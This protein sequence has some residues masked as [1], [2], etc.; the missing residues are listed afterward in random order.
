MAEE[1]M[2]SWNIGNVT[3]T[4]IVEVNNHTDPLAVLLSEGSPEL[5]KKYDW[6][7][8]DYATPEGDMKISFQCFVIKA[9]N[10]RIMID[11]CIGNDRRRVYDIFTNMHTSFL[12]DISLAGCPPESINTVLCT[13]LHF[14]H[15]GWNTHKV[16]GEWV[17]TFPNA[18]Y[19]FGRR[20]WEHWKDLP[21]DGSVEAEHLVDSVDPVLKA[22]LADFVESDHKVTDEIRLEPT[23]GHTPGHVSVHILSQGEEAVITGDLM[24]HPI[25]FAVPEMKGNFCMDPELSTKTRVDFI[26]RYENRKAFIIGS[27]FC[28]PTGGWILRDKEN[29]RFES[30]K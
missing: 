15:T 7:F 23:P 3:V 10:H 19:L 13:H 9:G 4:R 27:H 12:D 2:K 1:H 25:Q 28:D 21:R 5:M 16:D 22:G 6:L 18:R 20:E 11:T 14:D 30:G 24:H 26:R 17:P 8:P 29:W